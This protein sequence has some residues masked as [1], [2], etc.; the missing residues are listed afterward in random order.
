M[1]SV[2]RLYDADDALLYV[3][4]SL[5]PKGRLASHKKKPWGKDIARFEVVANLPRDEAEELER[6]LIREQQPCYNVAD[7]FGWT[8]AD[9]AQACAAAKRSAA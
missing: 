3:G 1:S 9:I 8:A 7:K 4:M 2:Y 5:Y 6:R